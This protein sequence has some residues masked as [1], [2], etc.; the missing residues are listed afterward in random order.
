VDPGSG[1]GG[2]GIKL[3]GSTGDTI[4]VG[5]SGPA[6]NDIIGNSGDGIRIDSASNATIENN[7]NGM[8]A[9]G[10]RLPNGGNGIELTGPSNTVGGVG[11]GNLISGNAGD[12]IS[13][14]GTAAGPNTIFGNTIG[15]W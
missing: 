10:D 14:H 4:G 8:D 7:N 6:S 3:T 2:D 9:D 15:L 11:A 5:V 1:N 12:G 13:I